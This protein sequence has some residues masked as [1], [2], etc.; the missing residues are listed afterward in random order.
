MDILTACQAPIVGTPF[1]RPNCP[2]CGTM[3]LVAEQSAFSQ[4][5][6]IHHAWSC[7]DCGNE[8]VTSISVFPS[9]R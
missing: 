7:D 6:C 4:N 5:G 3:L 8:F 9:Q 2:R 1:S